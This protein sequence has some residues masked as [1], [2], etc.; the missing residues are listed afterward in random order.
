MNQARCSQ[1]AGF[2]LSGRKMI[3]YENYKEDYIA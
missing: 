3:E 1:A 2:L